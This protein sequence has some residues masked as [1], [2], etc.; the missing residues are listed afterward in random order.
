MM[1]QSSVLPSLPFSL[2]AA[3]RPQVDF[4]RV[5][6]NSTVPEDPEMAGIVQKYLDLIGEWFIGW[7]VVWSLKKWLDGVMRW[8]WTWRQ[9]SCGCAVRRQLPG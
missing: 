3:D 1:C 7:S 8:Y 4:H 5:E 9:S 2:P 6:I